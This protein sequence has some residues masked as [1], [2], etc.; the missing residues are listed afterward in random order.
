MVDNVPADCVLPLF[1]KSFGEELARIQLSV[2]FQRA[3]PSSWAIAI[4]LPDGTRRV[5]HVP[6]Q[7]S[8]EDD[9]VSLRSDVFQ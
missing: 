9:L 4:P 6:M 1:S 7:T 5:I 2:F 8:S 3:N